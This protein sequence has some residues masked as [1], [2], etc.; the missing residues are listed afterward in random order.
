MTHP[1]LWD[2]N[3]TIVNDERYHQ[4]SWRILYE[5]NPRSMRTPTENEFKH[6][7]FGRSEKSTLEYLLGRALP[8]DELARWSDERVDIVKELFGP[9]L[10]LADG[11]ESL[12]EE[13]YEAG[14]R[15]AVVSGGSRWNYMSFI[16]DG[17]GIRRYFGN[18]IVTADDVT[19]SKPDPEGYVR[20]A[21]M[22]GALPSDCFVFEDTLSGIEAGRKAGAVV[23]AVASTHKPHELTL[24]HK[25]IPT[26]EDVTLATLDRIYS[27][28]RDQRRGGPE[29]R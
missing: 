10:K 19:H 2:L 9:H 22:L 4:Q 28:V 27:E 29:K 18:A 15:M 7:I 11:L 13:S 6:R 24:A 21:R 16:L 3:G 8:L 14:T 26:F 1:Q 17:L 20:G 5:R 25:V 23:I 12:L